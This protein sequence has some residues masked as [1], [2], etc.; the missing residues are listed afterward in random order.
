MRYVGMMNPAPLSRQETSALSDEAIVARVLAGDGPIF[1]LL[2]RR[3]NQRLYRMARSVLHDDLEAEDVVQDTYV[4]AFTSMSRFEGRSSVATWLT[5]IAFHEALRRRRRHRQALKAA[6]VIMHA[7]ADSLPQ[8]PDPGP[9]ARQE[10]S[11][12]LTESLDSLP[13]ELRSVVMLR[14][15]Q[16][17][18]TRETAECLRI[19]EA[20]VK[21]RLHRG[22]HMLAQ[23]VQRR[24]APR[25]A[26]EFTFGSERCDRVVAGVFQRLGLHGR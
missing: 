6:H 16:G 9:E 1:E 18:S 26:Q 15:V 8:A 10:T 24:I 12:M 7:R 11:I 5:R 21:V 3:H 20:N 17:L 2:M 23:S 14:L 19:S 25:L 13:P 22:R 4:R